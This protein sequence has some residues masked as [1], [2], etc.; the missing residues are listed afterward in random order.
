MHLYHKVN[1]AHDNAEENKLIV[2]NKDDAKFAYTLTFL[3]TSVMRIA[4]LIKAT[5][6]NRKCL[7]K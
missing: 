7:Q 4:T 6:C 5:N 3:N 1:N 2:C